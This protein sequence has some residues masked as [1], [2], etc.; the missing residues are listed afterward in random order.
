MLISLFKNSNVQNKNL[1]IYGE[2]AFLND[3]LIRDYLNN[4]EF[5]GLDLQRID[6][7]NDG[8]DELLAS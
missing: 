5:K 1:L 2:D 6:C 4:S 8:L 7:E 3:Y